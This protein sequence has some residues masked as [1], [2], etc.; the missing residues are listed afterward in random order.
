MITVRPSHT[1]GQSKWSWLDS[2]HTFSFGRY[3]DREHV[4]F[5]SLRVIND[6][7]VA[8]GKGFEPHP[9]E[10]M[11]II[12]YVVS[13]RLA[14]KDQMEDGSRHAHESGAGSVQVMSAGRSVTHSEFNPSP[15][16]ASRFL[17]IWIIPDRDGHDPMYAQ[18]DFTDAERR[19]KLVPIVGPRSKK[20]DAP[21]LINQDATV[22]STLLAPGAKVGHAIAKGRGVY[23]QVVRGQIDLDG[24]ALGEGDGAAIENEGSIVLTGT[25]DAD[26]LVFDLA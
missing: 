4:Q 7:I 17:Q 6:D 18:R 23:V 3:I 24:K 19:N 5:R 20:T 13:G 14:H 8:A 22:Y 1:R 25:T 2:K 10:D 21:L 16:E 11:E 26:V 15:T 9:H 12:S